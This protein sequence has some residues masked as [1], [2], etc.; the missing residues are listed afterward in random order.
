MS[1]S[2]ESLHVTQLF[3]KALM[4]PHKNFPGNKIQLWIEFAFYSTW[5][6]FVDFYRRYFT[7]LKGSKT[8]HF[9]INSPK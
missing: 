8:Y 1:A 6:S 3:T 9:A 7:K 2:E 5:R 4:V